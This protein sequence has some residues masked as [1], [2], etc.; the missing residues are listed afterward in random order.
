[1][2]KRINNFKSM[3]QLLEPLAQ[4]KSKA[5][6]NKAESNWKKRLKGTRVTYT[7][8]TGKQV[9][10]KFTAT[11]FLAL[12]AIA[13]C[14]SG[15]WHGATNAN[16]ETMVAK[17][18][19]FIK[20]MKDKDSKNGTDYMGKREANYT[21][22]TLNT[23]LRM[24]EEVGAINKIRINSKD[25]NIANYAYVLNPCKS[26]QEE[27]S[28]LDTPTDYMSDYM[29]DYMNSLHELVTWENLECELK[30][31]LEDN[32]VANYEELSQSI[33]QLM[34]KC[35]SVHSD[36]NAYNNHHK[37]Q[38]KQNQEQANTEKKETP[39][40]EEREVQE[41]NP[42]IHPGADTTKTTVETPEQEAEFNAKYLIN[43]HKVDDYNNVVT[44]SQWKELQQVI[45]DGTIQGKD[46]T[47][48]RRVLSDVI[49]KLSDGV[50]PKHSLTGMFWGFW[51]NDKL[52]TQA[53]VP[54]NPNPNDNDPAI[55]AML[56]KNEQERLEAERKEKLAYEA[57]K[58]EL[59]E[60]PEEVEEERT[61]VFSGVVSAEE[62]EARK[63]LPKH[64]KP[65]NKEDRE[66]IMELQAQPSSD[67]ERWANAWTEYDYT[68]KEAERAVRLKFS[69]NISNKF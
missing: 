65:S 20:A 50:K 16:Q 5:D 42:V 38:E 43:K 15:R 18:N 61:T 41:K 69:T 59:E 23:S 49:I 30:S 11:T 26:L 14:S 35:L 39:A 1:M 17:I 67:P 60:E 68:Y 3:E 25:D 8:K 10:K 27:I 63:L 64:L 54:T 28:E 13:I 40:K 24:L 2:D 9:T 47:Q 57:L 52:S 53:P 19:Q 51:K 34:F 7:T 37:E 33:L 55:L 31:L 56:A 4:F 12:H 46:V 22:M 45:Y 62:R 32:S 44:E 58:K 66:R 6:M 21:R 36:L 48:L 29:T